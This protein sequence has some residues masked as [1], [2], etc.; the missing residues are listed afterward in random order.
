[1]VIVYQH[2]PDR[3]NMVCLEIQA[4][5]GMYESLVATQKD[6]E[7]VIGSISCQEL[8]RQLDGASF[9]RI[10]FGLYAFGNAVPCSEPT[11]FSEPLFCDI[12][13]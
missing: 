10:M 1:M 7:D 13:D 11:E 8:T 5:D 12:R 3:S 2:L 9:T 6:Y 4:K